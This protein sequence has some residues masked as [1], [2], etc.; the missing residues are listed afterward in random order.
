MLVVPN[1]PSEEQDLYQVLPCGHCQTR[2]KW[3][4]SLEPV[5]CSVCQT[6]I[7]G[8]GPPL[9]AGRIGDYLHEIRDECNNLENLQLRTDYPPKTPTN[10]A[11]SDASQESLPLVRTP[12]FE[13]TRKLRLSDFL[14]KKPDSTRRSSF[15]SSSSQTSLLR[16]FNEAPQEGIIKGRPFRM[17]F[18]MI[19]MAAQYVMK[20]IGVRNPAYTYQA[21]AISADCTKVALVGLMDFLIYEVPPNLRFEPSLICWGDLT[22]RYGPQPRSAIELEKSKDRKQGTLS[23]YMAT[24]TNDVLAIASGNTYV[25]VRNAKTGERIAQLT[26]PSNSQCRAIVFSPDGQNLAVGLSQ[27]EI[28]VYQ[29]GL[30]RD[31]GGD[32]IHLTQTNNPITTIVFS[33]DSLLMVV[34]TKDNIIR[35]YRVDNLTVGAFEEYVKPSEYGKPPKPANISDISL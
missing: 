6:T 28:F 35:A 24:L 18:L 13:S 33:H 29:A 2:M 30:V 19:G 17:R 3:S 8:L 10:L 26:L 12:S 27:G 7:L 23:Y 9:P 11:P 22:K 4:H 34:C 5:L 15:D 16:S 14:F 1:L 32:P 31:F 25:D 21:T 20:V